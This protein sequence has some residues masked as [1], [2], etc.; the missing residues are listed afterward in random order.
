MKTSIS[1]DSLDEFAASFD[2]SFAEPVR[3]RRQPVHT[4]YG[5]A[6]LFTAN[7][8]KKLGSLATKSLKTFAH[9]AETFSRIFSIP[10]E[11]ADAV[12]SRVSKKLESEAIEDLRVDF[13]DGYGVRSEADEDQ[14]AV[15]AATETAKAME[16]NGLPPFF[17]IR[18]KSFGKETYRRSIR[19]LDIYLTTLTTSSGGKLPKNFVVTLPKVVSNGHVSALAN[20]LCKL[21]GKLGLDY[22]TIKVEIMIET[23]RSIFASDGTLAIPRLIEAGHGRISAAHFGA[24]D[25]TADLGIISSKQDLRHPACDFARHIMQISLAGTGVHMSDGAT[26][27]MPVGPRR[28]DQLTPDQM[29]ANQRVIHAAWKHHY[30]NCRYGLDNGFYQGWDLHPAQ[31][32]A[33]YAAVYTFFLDGLGDAS[34]RLKSFIEKGARANLVGNTFDD[35]ATGQG[36][37]NFFVRAIN[38]GAISENEVLERTGLSAENLRLGSFAEI[39]RSKNASSEP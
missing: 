34:E 33:R 28:G 11:H 24:Y 35:A 9:D 38:C 37:L 32:P 5:G 22:G 29:S 15:A 21:E 13:E 17:G 8:A 2:L 7:T 23:A 12:F 14:H 27:I 10:V 19:T 25:Y 16:E 4:V 30:E 6:Q 39:I 36:L 20:I 31:F 3:D 1:A 18:I 26:N